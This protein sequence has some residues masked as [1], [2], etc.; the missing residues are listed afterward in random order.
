MMKDGWKE[1]SKLVTKTLEEHS[2][3]IKE[4]REHVYRSEKNICQK[5]DDLGIALTEK[6]G[7]I[8]TDL[9]VS[10]TRIYSFAGGIGGAISLIVSLVS[11][12]F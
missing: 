3:E 12:L 7:T 11:K 8:N 10:K 2:S 5:I 9:Q 1:N 6:L 4:L